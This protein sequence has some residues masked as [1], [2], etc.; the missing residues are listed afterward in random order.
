MFK[1]ERSHLALVSSGCPPLRA[2]SG[3]A[4]HATRDQDHLRPE[5][6]AFRGHDCDE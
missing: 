3:G 4:R 2:D 6:A 5:E 1:Q